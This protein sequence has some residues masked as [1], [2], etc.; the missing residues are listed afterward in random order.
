MP[1][2]WVSI[3]PQAIELEAADLISPEMNP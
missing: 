1:F 2:D 3:Q